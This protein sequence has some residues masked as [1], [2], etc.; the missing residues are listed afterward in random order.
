MN[1]PASGSPPAKHRHALHGILLSVLVTVAG[2]GGGSASSGAGGGTPAPPAPSAPP[3]AGQLSQ[4]TG[5]GLNAGSL[6]MYVYVPAGLTANRPLVV[7][8]PGCAGHA[9]EYDTETGWA[10]WADQMQFS[11]LIPEVTS[12][13]PNGCFR[14][15]DPAHQARGSGEPATIIEM[16]DWMK[17]HYAVDP[18]RVFVTGFSG[19]GG[20]TNVMLATYP[21][22]FAAGA[23]VAGFP[24][25]CAVGGSEV[26]ACQFSALTKTP[27]QWGDLVRAAN[28][29]WHGPWPRVSVWNGTADTTVI[30]ANAQETMQQWTDVNGED[31]TPET[32]ETVAGYPHKVYGAAKVETYEVTGMGHAIPIKPGTDPDS[33]GAG[34]PTASSNICGSL[35]IARWFGLDH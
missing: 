32:D 9:A 34:G 13:Q 22:V 1:L 10:K 30:P 4:V 8:L 29:S 12:V 14:W 7:I 26:S 33:C 3:V 35:Y 11:L 23:P 6:N 25:K 24:Y 2:C 16:V 17:S 28:P 31:Q 5:F 20:E 18:A 21:D 15:Y 27:Q 19:G